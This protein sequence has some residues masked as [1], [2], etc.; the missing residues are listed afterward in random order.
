MAEL[1][2]WKT[3]REDLVRAAEDPAFG[4][5]T[6]DIDTAL[7]RGD[8]CAAAF[9]GERLVSYV[10]RSF[11]TARY[12]DDVWVEIRT[13]YRYAYKGFTDPTTAAA[14]HRT[15]LRCLRMDC[16]CA[17]THTLAVAHRAP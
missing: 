6:A 12:G 1:D 17:W 3:N 8:I 10:W 7:A 11:S 13:P 14:S 9:D 5:A 15:P 2:A 4:L 16:V